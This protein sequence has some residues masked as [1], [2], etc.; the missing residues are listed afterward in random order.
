MPISERIRQV[1]DNKRETFKEFCA[2]SDVKY[3]TLQHYLEGR[4]PSAEFLIEFNRVWGVSADWILTGKGQMYFNEEALKDYL[5]P[6]PGEI[7]N[8]AD[9]KNHYSYPSNA[10]AQRLNNFINH[11]MENHSDDEQA[12]LEIDFKQ[13]YQDYALWLEAQDK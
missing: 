7:D 11:W 12:W 6:A 5:K 10:R 2:Q 3:R 1:F 4:A 9:E 8:V 13:H